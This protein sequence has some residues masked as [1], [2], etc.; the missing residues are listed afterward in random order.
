MSIYLLM[1]II[2]FSLA[3]SGLVVGVTTVA[4]IFLN[5]ASF[6]QEIDHQANNKEK[7]SKTYSELRSQLFSFPLF[8]G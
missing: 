6:N 8:T 4:V 3:V 5:S 2:L 1:V 7:Q